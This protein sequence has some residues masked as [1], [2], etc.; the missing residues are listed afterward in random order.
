MIARRPGRWVPWIVLG[1]AVTWLLVREWHYAGWM[2]DDAFI[3][4]RY[5]RNL[6]RGL[7]LVFN[8]GERVEGYT[9]FLWTVLMAGAAK[10]GLDIPSTAQV[11]GSGFSLATLAVLVRMPGGPSTPGWRVFPAVLLCVSE[12]WAAWAVGGLESVFAAFLVVVAIY[13]FLRHQSDRKPRLL[14][15]AAVA[16]S[17]AA[18]THPSHVLVA[19]VLA[20]ALGAEALHRRSTTALIRFTAVFVALFGTYFL[21][22]ALYYGALLP[23]TF[24]AKVGASGSVLARGR[25]YLFGVLQAFPFLAL[26]VVGFAGLWIRRRRGTPD[27]EPGASADWDAPVLLGLV[28]LYLLYALAIGGDAFPA[29]RLLV[30]P[31]P[32]LC[33]IAARVLAP[34]RPRLRW[35]VAAVLVAGTAGFAYRHPK[36]RELDLA[37]AVDNIAMYK[38]AGLWMKQNFP[39]GSVLAYSGAGV[40]PYYGEMRFIDTL[41]LVD[42]HIARTRTKA[43]GQGLAGHEKGDGRYVLSREPDFIMF[44]GTPISSP[45]PNFKTDHELL[46]IQEFQFDYQVMRVPL[47]YTARRSG[48][49]HLFNLFLYRRIAPHGRS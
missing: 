32:L 21:L 13:A 14:V 9:N 4:F 37:V 16:A 45:A 25:A 43:I 41:G 36:H 40:V 38:T 19:L 31:L 30:V 23:N 3:S 15:G 20:I 12:S 24:Y 6:A 10:L 27:A 39:A 7:G 5:A 48:K 1:A 18:M 11:L 35:M 34:L 26:A 2:D 49:V 42:A 33:L 46:G 29:L 8:P 28:A 47:R 22:R 17:L 44:T